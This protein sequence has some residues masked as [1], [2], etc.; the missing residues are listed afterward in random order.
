MKNPHAG[1]TRSVMSY[2]QGIFQFQGR[3]LECA[4]VQS[5]HPSF[6]YHLDGLKFMGKAKGRRENGGGGGGGGGGGED[7]NQVNLHFPS[8]ARCLPM[9]FPRPDMHKLRQLQLLLAIVI[10]VAS[11]GSLSP[12]PMYRVVFA[13]CLCM[14]DVYVRC[15]SRATFLAEYTLYTV[16]VGISGRPY[17][18]V[19]RAVDDRAFSSV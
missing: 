4:H 19:R 12:D 3:R 13:S 8:R 17:G 14:W 11:L 2:A 6:F 16:Q 10:G 1:K 7:P 15:G 18:L 9:Q 5:F